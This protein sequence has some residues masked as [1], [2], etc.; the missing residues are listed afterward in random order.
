MWLFLLFIV[1]NT[2]FEN[3]EPLSI[4]VKISWREIKENKFEYPHHLTDETKERFDLKLTETLL[5]YP[6]GSREFFGKTD[7]YDNYHFNEFENIREDLV[8]PNVDFKS[9]KIIKLL[10]A[11]YNEAKRERQ[12]PMAS[13][14][15]DEVNYEFD[16]NVISERHAERYFEIRGNNAGSSSSFVGSDKE[17]SMNAIRVDNVL[18]EDGWHPSAGSNQPMDIDEVNETFEQMDDYSKYFWNNDEPQN[19]DSILSPHQL[20]QGDDSTTD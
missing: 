8:Y 11:K 15:A 19:L 9:N 10:R 5:G 12:I 13:A 20:M 3:V 14:A 6:E 2:F 16:I 17:S 1:L 18:P 7:G 4:F